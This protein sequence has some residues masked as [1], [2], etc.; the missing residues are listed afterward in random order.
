[1]LYIISLEP[2]ETRYTAQWQRWFK[3]EF[4]DAIEISGDTLSELSNAKNFLDPFQTNIWKSEQ[5][6]KLSNLFR[7]KKVKGGDKFLFLDAWHYGVIALKYMSTLSNIPIK[8][9]GMWHAGSYDPYDLLGSL[10]LFPKFKGFEQSL[11]DCLDQSYVATNFHKQLIISRF[12]KNSETINDNNIKVTGFPYKFDELDKYKGMK[13]KNLILFPHRLS[14]E[15]Q[16]WILKDLE[17]ELNKKGIEVIFCQE[18]KL[19]KEQYHKLLGQAKMIFSASL[20]ETWGI[21]LQEGM[22]LGAIPFVPN[23]LSY[24]EMYYSEFHYNSEWTLNK[25]NFSIYK[26]KILQEIILRL[27]NYTSYITLMDKNSEYLKATCSTMVNIKKEV[28][29]SGLK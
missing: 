22:Y 23:R 8:I 29:C 27:S 19:K 21:G 25:D 11:F 6:V 12:E 24:S 10:N 4:P 13:K 15:K 17:K 7:D 9:F 5:I 18:K 20:Q 1:M 28:L 14:D 2:L 16:P 26:H 3:E